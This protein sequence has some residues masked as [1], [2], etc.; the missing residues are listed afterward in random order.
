MSASLN[1]SVSNFKSLDGLFT[2]WRV[3]KFNACKLIV[4][5]VVVKKMT[6]TL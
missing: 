3:N 5:G 4:Q 6:A 2:L 1:F